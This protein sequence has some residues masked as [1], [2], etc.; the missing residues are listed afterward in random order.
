MCRLRHGRAG[1]RTCRG[2][3]VSPELAAEALFVSGLQP[4]QN[5]HGKAVQEAVTAMLLL[6]GSD[7]CAAAVAQAYGDDMTAAARRMTWCL[8]ADTA[9]FAPSTV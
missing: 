3:P 5:P 1:R 6:Y 4:S 9:A 2:V 7:G 8:T